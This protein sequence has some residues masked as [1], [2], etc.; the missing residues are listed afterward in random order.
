MRSFMSN[1][2][3]SR[4]RSI[5]IVVILLNLWIITV[6]HAQLPT[7]VQNPD[8]RE[9]VYDPSSF[10]WLGL[11]TKYRIGEKLWY[12]GEYH[13]RRRGDFINEMA[14]LYVRIGLSYLVKYNFEITGGIVTPLYWVDKSKYPEEVPIDKVLP[15]FRFWQQ[16][17]FIQSVGRTKLYHQ[18]RTEQRWRRDFI[19]DSPFLLTHRFRYKIMAYIPLSS[20]GLQINTMYVSMYNEIF[21]QAGKRYDT[22]LRRRYAMTNKN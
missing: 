14:Q 8:D 21:I 7:P 6:S 5:I 12:N 2:F 17:L 11:Y 3:A 16:Y 15:Q 22:T 9:K 13:I 19:K 4:A 1:S 18:I 10:F 20:R